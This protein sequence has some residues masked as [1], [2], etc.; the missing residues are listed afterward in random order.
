MGDEMLHFDKPPVMFAAWPGMGDVGLTAMEYIRKSVGAHLF[1]ELDMTPFYSPEEVIV[2]RGL[3]SFP[4]IPK[5]LFLEQHDPNMVFFESSLQMV[6]S[7]AITVAQAVLDVAHK[8]KARRIFTAAAFPYPMS[9]KSESKVFAAANNLRLLSDLES[10]GIEPMQEGYISG[11]NGLLLG[12]AASRDIEAAC[13]LATIPSYAGAIVYPKGSLAI[14]QA[15]SKAAS[16]SINTAELEKASDEYEATYADIEERLRQVFPS[17]TEDNEG[18][19]NSEGEEFTPK[20]EVPSKP[21]E[22]KIPEYVMNKIEHLF[23]EVA[24]NKN[25]DKAKELKH[26]LDKWKIFDLYEKRFLDLFREED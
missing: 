1:A 8:I 25:K 22:E 2:S 18:M 10:Y 4:E 17:M 15:L 21:A 23:S 13:I 24:K 12:I 19:F 14:V 16:F 5:S 26:E 7:D 9:F 20:E 3:V 11:L 6:G